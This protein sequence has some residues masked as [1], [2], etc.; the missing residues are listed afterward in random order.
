MSLIKS[1]AADKAFSKCVRER[2]LWKCERCGAQHEV[3]SQGLHCSHFYSRG[4]WSVRFEPLNAF[5]HCYGCH[6]YLSGRPEE[7][8]VWAQQA[9]GVKAYEVLIEKSQDISIGRATRKTKGIGPIARWFRDQ[10]QVIKDQRE[11]GVSGRI[12]FWGW[13]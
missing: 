12:E 11:Q 6:Q 7:F 3:N 5:A 8:R 9:M 1:T 2:S 4:N 10:H 13:E